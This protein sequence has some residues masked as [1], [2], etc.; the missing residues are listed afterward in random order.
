[1][2]VIIGGEIVTPNSILSGGSLVVRNGI[3]HDISPDKA[4]PIPQ[5]SKR[6]TADKLF[7]LPG[8]ISLQSSFLEKELFPR[9]RVEFPPERALVQ[10][11]KVMAASGI[12]EAYHTVSLSN[13]TMDSGLKVANVV[14]S[15][16]KKG[17]LLCT[18]RLHLIA[19]EVTMPIAR[20]FS[21]GGNLLSLLSPEGQA[22]N[23]V[24]TALSFM[25]R[26]PSA[27]SDPGHSSPSSEG[28]FPEFS[29]IF[30]FLHGLSSASEAKSRGAL[31]MAK[32]P[33]LVSSVPDKTLEQAFR[34]CLVDICVADCYAPSLIYA[35][36][37]IDRMGLMPLHE[38]VGL[39]SRAPAQ[40]IG[41]GSSKGS[42]EEGKCAD[43]CLVEVWEGIPRVIQTIIDGKVIFSI[44]GKAER[45]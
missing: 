16:Q 10:A 19:D 11:D 3:I 37:L 13:K 30:Q 40:I 4:V 29:A 5:G 25:A 17:S 45:T 2:T 44:E 27:E 15:T 20:T 21:H 39:A 12:V 6:I 42:L 33:Y 9:P 31:I 41:K 43:L 22:N 14:A 34:K 23:K 32:A 36:F 35:L 24:Q 26:K 1:M 38:A 28:S 7:I 8:L 18:H